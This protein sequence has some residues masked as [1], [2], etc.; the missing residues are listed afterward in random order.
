MVKVRSLLFFSLPVDIVHAILYSKANSCFLFFVCLNKRREYPMNIAQ[1]FPHLATLIIVLL[2]LVPCDGWLTGGSLSAHAQNRPFTAGQVT[3]YALPPG[4]NPFGSIASGPNG[5]LWFLEYPQ[6][7]VGKMTIHGQFTEYRIPTYTSRPVGITAGPDGNMWFTEWWGN[8]I[9][10]ITMSGHITEYPIPTANAYPADITLGPDGNLWFTEYD[11]GR[12]GKI[13]PQGQI[14]EYPEPH[15][16]GPFGIT[17]GPDG[18]LWFTDYGA[19]SL[20]KITLQ[21][22]ITIYPIHYQHRACTWGGVSYPYGITTGPDGNLWFTITGSVGCIGKMTL[23]GHFTTYTNLQPTGADPQGIT[24][25]PDGNLWFAEQAGAIGRMTPKGMET[26]Y[27]IDGVSNPD[28]ITVGPDRN[29][30]FVAPGDD[31]IGTITWH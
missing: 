28:G 2:L 16:A 9:G 15:G 6:N 29:L 4:H 21:G 12:I 19:H 22:Q 26:D 10:K 14:T 17:V 5:D 18:N 24:T 31:A 27:G 23:Q 13:T 25:G 1:R 20:G 8:N 3:E 7:M 11:G 30:W